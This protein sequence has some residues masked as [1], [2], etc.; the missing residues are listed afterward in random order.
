[1][2]SCRLH[3]GD[4]DDDDDDGDDD[5]YGY[6]ADDDGD[7]LRFGRGKKPAKDEFWICPGNPGSEDAARGTRV[8]VGPLF[9]GPDDGPHH[10]TSATKQVMLEPL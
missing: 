7:V 8:P 9:L 1:M 3:G 4:D 10:S 6:D 5:A 2:G